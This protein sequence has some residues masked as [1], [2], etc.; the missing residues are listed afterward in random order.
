MNN[1]IDAQATEQKNT[2]ATSGIMLIIKNNTRRFGLLTRLLHWSVALLIL[3][4]TW[5]GW[6]M[7]DLTYYDKWYKD[8]L[9]YHKSLGM[10]VLGLAMVK[11]GWQWYSPLPNTL[12]E[13][14][15]LERIAARLMHTVLL[16]SMIL[17]PLTGY[18][19]STSAGQPV[20]VFNWLQIPAVIAVDKG[21]RDL[22]IELHYYLAYAT[23]LLV[24]GHAGAAIKHQFI[25]KHDTLK[26]MLWG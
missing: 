18:L 22:V 25:D 3:G 8:S 12:T 20:A 16:T 24:A 9:D 17:L 7:V 5:L 19:I 10:L 21:L 11:L 2:G 23:L 14:K 15:P 4:L 13:L 26:R 1:T 6:Y